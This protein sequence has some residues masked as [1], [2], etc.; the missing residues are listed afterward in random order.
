MTAKVDVS[1]LVKFQ[2]RLRRAVDGKARDAFYE[3]C[4][5]ELAQRFLR[6][7]TQN[8]P[9]SEGHFEVVQSPDGRVV[10]YKRGKNKGKVKLK[11]TATGGRLQRAWETLLGKPLR[12]KKFRQHDYAILLVNNTEYASYVEYGHVQTP[13]RFIPV[14]G[15]RTKKRWVKGKFFMTNAARRVGE[16]SSAILKLRIQEYLE[17]VLNGQ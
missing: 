17:G 16:Q 8:T 10:K 13:G 7:V 6:D 1:E 2:D 14:L 11:Q 12:V 5:K 9:K 15:K 3:D 4:V